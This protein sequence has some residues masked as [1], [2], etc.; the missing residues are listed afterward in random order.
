DEELATDLAAIAQSGSDFKDV[1][2]D[3]VTR[4]INQYV[5]QGIGKGINGRQWLLI[6]KQLGQ[7]VKTFKSDPHIDYREVGDR[8]GDAQVALREWLERNADP[9]ILPHVEATNNAWNRFNLMQRAMPTDGTAFTPNQLMSAVRDRSSNLDPQALDPTTVLGR[10]F[11]AAGQ[12]VL[13]RPGGSSELGERVADTGLLASVLAGSVDPTY[14]A[15]LPGAAMYTRWGNEVL[16]W[17]AINRPETLRKMGM[18]LRENVDVGAAP[19]AAG[20]V[21]ATQD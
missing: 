10:R 21:S 17:L 7:L 6:D 13:G 5:Q 8:L 16:R 2:G 20:A 9:D 3:A 12:Q 11:A 18:G 1:V 15:A 4:H 19:A 14:L